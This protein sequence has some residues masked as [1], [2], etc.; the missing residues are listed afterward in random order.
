MDQHRITIKDIEPLVPFSRGSTEIFLTG[1]WS[2]R[3]PIYVEK[4]S[5]CRQGCPIGNDIA[6]AFAYAARGEYDEALRIYRQENPL[7]GVCGRVCYHP[8]EAECNRKDFDEAINIR[9]FERFLADHGTVDVRRELPL[10]LREERIAVIGSGPAGLSAA[11]HLARLG[12][13]VT[14]FEAMAEPG[15]MLRYAIPEYRLPRDVLQRELGYIEQ[16][17]VRIKTG[18]RV[19]KEVSLPGIRKD[20][21]AVFIAVG[22][23]R[24][25]GLD[26]EGEEHLPVV[27]G[28]EFLRSVNLGETIEPAEKTVIIGGGNTAVDCARA[29]RRLGGTEVTILYR[30]SRAEMPALPEDVAYAEREGITLTYLAA[31]K[32]L[33]SKNGRLSAVECVRMELGAP[34]A[35]GRPRPVAMPGTECIMPADRLIAAVGQV[36]D[37]EFLREPGVSVNSRGQIDVSPDTNATNLGGVFAGGDS[38]GARAF[39]ADAIADGK[40]AALAIHCFLEKKD[41]KKVLEENRIAEG[42][43]FSFRRFMNPAGYTADLKKIVSFEKVNTLCFAHAGRSDNPDPLKAEDA[44]STFK[45]VTAGL[46][47]K[48]AEAEISRCFKCGTCT[49]CDLCFLL[50]P[51]ISIVR[52]GEEGYTVRTD[53]CKGCGVC[54]TT[55]P[56]HVIEMGDDAPG[57]SLTTTGGGL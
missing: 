44:A 57:S 17:G 26:M 45:E 50:C 46:E 13:P 21:M 11:Y 15:G 42:R 54:A 48:M 39:V 51:D 2:P 32:R 37:T 9:G 43:S 14:V 16:L 18:V 41:V 20:Y 4:T 24:G 40:K 5:P 49:R 33:I 29:A 12:Y 8:C 27:E 1:H 53:F 25:T 7:P 56:R 3:K 47:P 30:R 6:R 38:A 36:P 23:H 19:G 55:C 22:A 35:S 10:L 31:P 52:L 28:I 34:D